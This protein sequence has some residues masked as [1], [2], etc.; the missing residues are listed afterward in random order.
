VHLASGK[1]LLAQAAV[2]TPASRSPVVPAWAR[3]T[4]EP[5]P[6]PTPTPCL[7]AA[8]GSSAPAPN[9]GEQ[10]FQRLPPGILTADGV[11]LRSAELAGRRVVVVGG[12]MAA[13][14]LAAGAAERGAAVTLV[15]CK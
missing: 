4:A 5:P 11:D 6:P 14:L 9:I 1:V 8:A 10:G 7:A 13:G 3:R 2:Y 12:G 15:C